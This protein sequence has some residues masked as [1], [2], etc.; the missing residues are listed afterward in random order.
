MIRELA[1]LGLVDTALHRIQ[2]FVKPHLIHHSETFR[3]RY[4]M[5]APVLGGLLRSME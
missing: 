4:G 5:T 2:K 3:K 1:R